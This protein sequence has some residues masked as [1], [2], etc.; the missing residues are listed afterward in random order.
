MN[1][2]NESSSPEDSP[3]EAIASDLILSIWEVMAYKMN[4]LDCFVIQNHFETLLDVLTKASCIELKKTVERKLVL[5][6]KD[7]S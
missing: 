6:S 4:T 2:T 1:K 7:F 5:T 3:K